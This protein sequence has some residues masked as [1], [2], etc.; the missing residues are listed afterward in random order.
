MPF[1]TKQKFCSAF[2][3]RSFDRVGRFNENGVFCETFVDACSVVLP[4][5]ETTDL[6]KLIDAGI[7]LKQI[8]TKILNVGSVELPEEKQPENKEVT[9]E[10]K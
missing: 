3:Y 4:S 2:P 7:D 5:P 6:G 8:N 10:D 9:D 1:P